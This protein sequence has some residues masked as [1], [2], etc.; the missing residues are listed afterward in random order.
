MWPVR[1]LQ[2]KSYSSIRSRQRQRDIGTARC[3]HHH[4]PQHLSTNTTHMSMFKPILRLPRR[5]GL[6]MPARS[7][8]VPGSASSLSPFSVAAPAPLQQQRSTYATSQEGLANAHT[9]PLLAHDEAFLRDG[10]PGLYSAPG[11]QQAWTRY[12]SWCIDSLNRLVEGTTYEG[13]S[14][15]DLANI[16]SREPDMASIFNYA[17]MAFNNHFFFETLSGTGGQDPAE[18]MPLT[19]KED[20]ELSFGSLE[21]LQRELIITANAMFGPGFVWLV[22]LRDQSGGPQRFPYRVLATYLAGSPF[23]AAHWR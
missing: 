23:P 6:V 21:T 8:A 17:S 12:Q 7:S 18:H 1:S 3:R 22:R 4:H 5:T 9:V 10:V 11:F 13:I 14:T 2:E 16:T 15:L 19:L 20:L